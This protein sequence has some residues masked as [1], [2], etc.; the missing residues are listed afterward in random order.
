MV[1][2]PCLTTTS[3]SKT[4]SGVKPECSS[5]S[6]SKALPEASVRSRLRDRQYSRFRTNT[7]RRQGRPRGILSQGPHERACRPL[8]TANPSKSMINSF[9]RWA[10]VSLGPGVA[11][12]SSATSSSTRRR[13]SSRLERATLPADRASLVEAGRKEERFPK[14]AAT[15]RRPLLQT[16]SV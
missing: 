16:F 14:S 13:S 11:S 2:T 15:R 5:R 10:G 1:L 8:P 7:N 3:E 4:Q 12:K 6:L 9:P